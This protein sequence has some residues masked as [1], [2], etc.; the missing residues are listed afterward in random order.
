M[1]TVAT[2]KLNPKDT[3]VVAR[4]SSTDKRLI[5]KAAAVNGQ[6]VAAF[7]VAKARTA[8]V[9]VL[10]ADSIIRLT[11]AETQRLTKALFAP[12]REVGAGFKR[13]LKLY[14]ETVNSDV[15]RRSAEVRRSLSSKRTAASR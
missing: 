11:R 2:R 7:I 12:P 6:T 14:R 1:P 3:R 8:A 13:A 15:N 4:V 5:E 9:E 10:E